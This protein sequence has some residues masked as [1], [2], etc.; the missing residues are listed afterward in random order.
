M[1]KINLS[2]SLITVNLNGLKSL[3]KMQRLADW[4]FFFL[5]NMVQDFPGGPVA[6]DFTLPL[7]G[8]WVPSLVGEV[9]IPQATQQ[10]QKENQK[11]KNKK[12]KKNRNVVLLYAFY[13]RYNTSKDTY[14]VETKNGKGNRY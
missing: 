14:K 8:V 9:K 1:A 5:R 13:K 7:Q 11:T 6:I 4:I 10:E 12:Q 3:H 2:L